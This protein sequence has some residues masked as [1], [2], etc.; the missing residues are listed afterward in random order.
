MECK[1]KNDLEIGKNDKEIFTGSLKLREFRLQ[2][3]V[4]K[5]QISPLG[6]VWFS[7]ISHDAE[8]KKKVLDKDPTIWQKRN[9]LMTKD[10]VR[11]YIIIQ[12]YKSWKQILVRFS[13]NFIGFQQLLC[14]HYS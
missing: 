2:T 7:S 3:S 8:Q 10:E 6:R 13:S 12:L 14:Q 4:L 11:Q 1:V 5:M 9:R